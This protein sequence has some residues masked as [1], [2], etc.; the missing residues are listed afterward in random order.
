MGVISTPAVAYITRLYKADAGVII[1]ASHN[2]AEYNGIKIFNSKGFKLDD[3]CETEIEDIVLNNKISQLTE[4]YN[5]EGRVLIRPSGTEPVVRV[6]IEGENIDEI[7]KD[8]KDLAH[9]I[10]NK[11]S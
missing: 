5:N 6:M 3:E 8:A 2:P 7:T 10:E 11:L 9:L 4:K 1:S